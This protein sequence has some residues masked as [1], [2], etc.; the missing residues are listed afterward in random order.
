MSQQCA[1]ILAAGRGTRLKSVT[2]DLPKPL[3]LLNGKPMVEHVMGSLRHAG[4]DK[5]LL[6]VGYRHE[7]FYARFA[8]DHSVHY[9]LQDPVDG[10][11]S[12]TR[13]AE[14]FTAG[15]PFLLIFGDI[16]AAPEDLAELWKRLMDDPEAAGVI[17]V[18]EVDDPYQGAA[19]YEENGVVSRI[20]E[21]PPIGTS[22]TRWNSAGIYAFRRV[23]FEALARIQKTERDEYELP[24]AVTMLL[25][26]GKRFLISPLVGA[27]RDVGRPE[28][29]A[30]AAEIT[31]ELL[32][33]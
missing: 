20:I 2:G 3:L 31:S 1:V 16:L 6:V 23:V 27:W 17:A 33:G 11:G 4:F 30:A 19:V 22:T 32:P 5:F 24:S 14:G 12:A 25:G 15:D 29:V 28:D 9:A 13:L 26:E 10:T 18:K 8:G 21:K 7:L